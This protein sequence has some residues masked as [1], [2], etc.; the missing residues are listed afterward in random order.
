M[1]APDGQ[2]LCTIDR[3]KAEWYITKELG[4]KV[5]DEPLTVQLKFEPAGR[6]VGDCGQ[7][8]LLIKNN[9]CVV[10][11][12]K[13]SLIRKNVVPREYRK[14]FPDV[15]K[16]H[17]SHDIVLLCLGCHQISNMN[18][19]MLRLRLERLCNAP[20]M[21]E[22]ENKEEV[23]QE[24]QIQ[25]IVR[26]LCM[27]NSQIPEYRIKELENQLLSFYPNQK[28]IDQT[29][30]DWVRNTDT[31]T[32][33][34]TSQYSGHGEIVVDCFKTNGEGLIALEKMW[35]LHFL[36]FMKPQFMPDLWS[37]DHNESR[38]DLSILDLLTVMNT[39]HFNCLKIFR[40]KIT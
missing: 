29:F 1:Q 6:A 36:D 39:I 12:Q 33:N 21:R 9:Q 18:D 40:R 11:G 3:K 35:R 14:F 19:H 4:I 32:K 5:A 7:F 27:Q 16:N 37:V 17:S 20:L 22:V 13:E 26:A 8:Y 34:I 23:D 10:C 2:L 24:K 15:M 30:L 28:E 38:L 25:K 31:S